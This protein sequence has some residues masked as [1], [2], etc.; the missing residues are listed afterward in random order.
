MVL[1]SVGHQV[2][3]SVVTWALSWVVW[4]NFCIELICLALFGHWIC[5][6]GLTYKFNWFVWRD[7]GIEM[8]RSQWLPWRSLSMELVCLA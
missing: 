3:F 1:I 6:C 5:L 4:C 8:S 7:L 2:Y